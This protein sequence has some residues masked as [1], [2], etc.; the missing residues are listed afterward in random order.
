MS[1]NALAGLGL[2]AAAV[3]IVFVLSS[4][5]SDEQAT[6]SRDRDSATGEATSALEPSAENETMRAPV[7]AH[8]IPELRTKASRDAASESRDGQAEMARMRAHEAYLYET[9]MPRARDC[10]KDIRGGGALETSLSFE[11]K[12]GR[13]MAMGEDAVRVDKSTLD[14][15]EGERAIACIQAAYRD[16]SWELPRSESQVEG[17]VI[18]MRQYWPSPELI[19]ARGDEASRVGE[20]LLGN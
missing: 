14:A 12:A 3:A 5:A 13:A 7:R 9:L 11:V 1:S 8:S 15:E 20:V 4:S 16:S 19:R 2:L 18:T 6:T 17:S 10:W